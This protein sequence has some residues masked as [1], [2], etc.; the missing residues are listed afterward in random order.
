[1]QNVKTVDVAVATTVFPRDGKGAA[2][3]VYGSDKVTGNDTVFTATTATFGAVVAVASGTA[4]DYV[5]TSDGNWGVLVSSTTTVITVDRWRSLGGGRVTGGIPVIPIAGS[6]VRIYEGKN[7]EVGARGHRI[8][9]INF[10]L[11]TA[12]DTFAITDMKG[13]AIWTHTVPATPAAVPIDFRDGAGGGF[14][15]EGPFG[16]KSSA[17]TTKATV[18]YVDSN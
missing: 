16:F 10:T 5:A 15:V 6:I 3:T 4:G 12:A 1:M 7:I 13:T 8:L 17:T 14:P 11:Q 2:T 18:T 9:E